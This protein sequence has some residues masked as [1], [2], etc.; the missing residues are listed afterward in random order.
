VAVAETMLD[1]AGAFLAHRRLALVG[2]SR[3]GRDFSRAVLREL[4]R[5]G[6]DVVP[7]SPHLAEA[8]GL[9]A[10]A[11]VRDARPPVEAA[12]LLTPP[13]RS[14]EAVEDCLAA[15]VRA[16]WLHRG[17]GPGSASPEAVARCRAAGVEPVTDLCPFMALPG[18]GW[19]HRLH[20]AL[21]R[22]SLPR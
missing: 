1:R 11:R 6:Y 15:G 9:R 13:A 22:R 3:D 17:A 7:V 4:A 19:F 18:A 12:L 14:L 8:E 5:R 2:V 10:V 21:R 20:A 16:I